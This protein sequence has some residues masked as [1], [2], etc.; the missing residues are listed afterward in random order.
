M[1]RETGEGDTFVSLAWNALAAEAFGPEW[2]LFR[3]VWRV[4]RR[5][6][7]QGRSL[8]VVNTLA[9]VGSVA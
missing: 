7:R 2:R 9:S 4:L 8:R 5:W 3:A 1:A 6:P